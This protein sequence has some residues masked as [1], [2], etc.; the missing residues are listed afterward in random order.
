MILYYKNSFN[1]ELINTKKEI[2]YAEEMSFIPI[3]YNKKD[4][5]K[6]NHLVFIGY[7][8]QK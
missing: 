3:R 6:Q 2:F 5:L 4:L 7:E 1:K 8:I